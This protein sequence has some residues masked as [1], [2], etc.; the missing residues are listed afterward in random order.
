MYS[1]AFIAVLLAI[2]AAVLAVKVHMLKKAADEIGKEL[3]EVLSSDTNLLIRISSGD[4]HMRR[5]AGT[6]N[7]QLKELR[8]EKRRYQSGNR[9]IKEAVT[10]ISHD[11]RT[12]LTA[13][14]GYTDLIRAEDISSDAARYLGIIEGR[15]TSL[16][17]LT[18]ELFEY[19]LIVSEEAV[20]T[21]EVELNRALEESVAGYY[22][23]LKQK[24]L[25]VQTDI[26]GTKVIRHMNKSALSR[27]FS[28]ILSNIVKYSSGDM[29]GISLTEK[30]V[31]CFSN[32]A[33]TMDPVIVGRLFDRFYTVE[34]GR[35]STGLGLSIAKTL[36][37]QM[38]G[39]IDAVYE[40]GRLKIYVVFPALI[41]KEGAK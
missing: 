33:E 39:S 27:I 13:I 9:E 16:S 40:E 6:L 34:S 10:N 4:K 31:I 35:K 37:E 3:E 36:T 15:I 21:E 11:L 20:T 30:G 25:E 22:G 8:S 7:V 19:S 23:A 28:N 5:L 1:L 32:E 26:T 41:E 14:M 38:K 17:R 2:V 18:N 24:G 29:V 12:P